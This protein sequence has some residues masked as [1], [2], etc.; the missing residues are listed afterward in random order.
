[1]RHVEQRG[2]THIMRTIIAAIL[3]LGVAGSVW[4]GQD[5]KTALLNE[6][7][8]L[9]HSN[10]TGVEPLLIV[11]MREESAQS[12]EMARMLGE[13]MRS[14]ARLNAVVKQATFEIL[15]S[16]LSEK[17]LKQL[18]TFF[19]SDAGKAYCSAVSTLAKERPIRIISALATPES[20]AR[21][22][23][24]RTMDD[25]RDVATASEAYATDTNKYP[26]VQGYEGLRQVL[27]P[28]YIRSVPP[29]DAWGRPF[30]YLV[31][32][33]KQHYRFASAGPDGKFDPASLQIGKKP[34]QSDDI[35]FED[36]SFVYY[37][38]SVNVK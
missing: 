1:M 2:Y 23:E 21:S 9:T 7:I 32:A 4:A 29:T 14:D 30:A 5:N 10:E 11:L 3:A 24:K 31:S 26:E 13:E 25:M 37:P 18:V 35:I 27:S 19:K 12:A 16:R 22:K 34:V 36:G 8:E 17:Q 38:A 28:T 20:V 15:A 6:L 33:D